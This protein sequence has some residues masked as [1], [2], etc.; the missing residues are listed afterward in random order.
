M[1]PFVALSI[2]LAS[3]C[4]TANRANE[5]S[6]I[7]VRSEMRAQVVCSS[8]PL[9]AEITLEGSRVFLLPAAFRAIGGR[10]LRIGEIQNVV[11]LIRGITRASTVAR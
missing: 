11:A 4:F 3:E 6:L 7:R 1:Q 2:V 8:K 10:P 5:R 9:R